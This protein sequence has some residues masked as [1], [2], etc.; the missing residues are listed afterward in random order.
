M[1]R[2]RKGEQT[3]AA[4]MDAARQVLR[5]K[6]YF[7]ATIADI[8]KEAGK[9]NGSFH[10]YFANKDE[11]LLAL[12]ADGAARLCARVDPAEHA[13]GI[14]T[15]TG[16]RA[17]VREFWR[18]FQENQAE[19]VA[20]FQAAMASDDFARRWRGSHSANI[21]QLADHL[22]ESQAHG[23]LPGLDPRFAAAAMSSMLEHFCLTWCNPVWRPLDM[24]DDDAEQAIDTLTAMALGGIRGPYDRPE[25]GVV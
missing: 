17:H 10:N 11:L 23:Y 9:A 22:R 7:N 19:C 5:R 1:T 14:H 25:S 3:E 16:M 24:Q 8:T 12:T 21:E 18:M 13:A 4:L 15:W 2:G 20:V 6:G